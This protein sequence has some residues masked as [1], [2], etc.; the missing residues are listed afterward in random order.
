M[1]LRL[2]KRII[3][4]KNEIKEVIE[5]LNVEYYGKKNNNIKN[6][7]YGVVKKNE[8]GF[9]IKWFDTDAITLL[10]KSTQ[11]KEVLSNCGWS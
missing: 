11:T 5:G 9:F 3:T 7:S 8:K 4:T 2:T 1:E 6:P 10:D